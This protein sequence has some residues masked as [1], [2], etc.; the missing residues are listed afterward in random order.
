M[1]RKTFRLA[2]PIIHFCLFIGSWHVGAV[3]K[4]I[5][6][7]QNPM[8]CDATDVDSA[9]AWDAVLVID[10]PLIVTLAPLGFLASMQNLPGGTLFAILAIVTSFFWFGFASLVDRFPCLYPSAG[11]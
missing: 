5:F 2:F 9:R 4:R 11:A 10:F 1:N 3:E 8:F 6:C 7:Q